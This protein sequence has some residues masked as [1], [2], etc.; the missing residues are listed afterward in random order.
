[1]SEKE[2]R[3]RID[4]YMKYYKEE[5]MQEKLVYHAPNEFGGMAAL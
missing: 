1:M 2:V 3:Q 5:R 4:S